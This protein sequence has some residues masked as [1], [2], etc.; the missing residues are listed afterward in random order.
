MLLYYVI[1]KNNKDK[2]L[3]IKQY[4]KFET[5]I[6]KIQNLGSNLKYDIKFG[7]VIVAFVVIR[8]RHT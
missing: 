8:V 5:L 1:A 3:R 6:I 7:Y 2:G 4:H